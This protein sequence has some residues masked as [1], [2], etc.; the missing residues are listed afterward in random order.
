MKAKCLSGSALK[1]LAVTAMLVDHLAHFVWSHQ[2]WAWEPLGF[3]GGHAITPMLLLRTFGRLA[4][5][6]FA[7]LLVEGFVHTR[8]RRRYGTGL[9]LFALLSEIPFNLV[10]GGAWYY[11]PGRNVFFTLLLGFLG[12]CAIEYLRGDRRNET[13]ALLG[14]LLFSFFFRADYGAAGFA[15]IVMLYLLRSR[16]LYQAVVGCL[17]L[18]SRWAA[19]L[20]FIPISLYDGRRGFIRGAVGKYFF[21]AFYPLH[22]SVIW[23]FMR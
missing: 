20:A 3:Y 17:L 13:V 16:V 14:L 7:F 10:R 1:V 8:S 5:P 22:L 2:A 21:Y 4:F 9:A 12:L 18:P 15:F 11:A 23:W 6:I 19:G